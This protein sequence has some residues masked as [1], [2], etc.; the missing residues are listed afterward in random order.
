MYMYMEKT[1][2]MVS[3]YIN[4]AILEFYLETEEMSNFPIYFSILA[5]VLLS[6]DMPC[7]CK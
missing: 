6:L 3:L 4:T 7:L 2:A 5:L 1:A